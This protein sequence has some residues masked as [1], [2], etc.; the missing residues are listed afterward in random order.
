MATDTCTWTRNE[1]SI[2]FV[3]GCDSMLFVQVPK[4]IA[5][6]KFCPR[7]G[8]ALVVAKETKRA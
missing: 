1:S 2:A 8:K 5:L 4:S 7:C 6:F 3:T